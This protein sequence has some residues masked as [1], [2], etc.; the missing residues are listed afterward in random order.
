MGTIYR[1][2]AKGQAEIETRAHHLT[3][4]LRTP[5]IM[6]DGRKT[7]ED[8]R[9]LIAGQPDE[10]LHALLEQGFIEIVAPAAPAPRAAHAPAS[11]NESRPPSTVPQS[12][13]PPSTHPPQS[14][15]PVA[16]F[17]DVRRL[18]V[19]SLTDQLGPAAESIALKIERA[20]NME[21]L[22]PLL[23]AARDILRHAS[24][25]EAA[26]AFSARFLAPPG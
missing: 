18:A 22:R 23:V 15:P 12:T 17:E 2:T 9:K 8:L 20:R 1:K 13:R 24:G 21:E 4:R 10:I 6:V 7:D 5:L 3:P 26:A 16:R 25:A 19:R 11:A 14:R